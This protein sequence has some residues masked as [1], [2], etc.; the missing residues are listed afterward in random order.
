MNER[1]IC[2]IGNAYYLNAVELRNLRCKTNTVSNTAYRGFGGPQGMFVIENIID[3]I[4]RYLGCDPVEIRQR[5]FFAEQPGAGR[6][7]ALW[8]RSS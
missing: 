7:Y 3:D 2:H 1:A 4:A 6:P 5:N 8:G